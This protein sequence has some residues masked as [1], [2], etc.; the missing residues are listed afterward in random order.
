MVKIDALIFGYRSIRISPE[1]LSSVTSFL[2]RASIPSVINSDGSIIVRERD[3]IKTKDILQGRIEFTYSEPRGLYGSWKRLANKWAIVISLTLAVLLV[4][5]LSQLIWDIRVEGNTRI[6]DAQ[7]ISSLKECGFEIG[8]LWLMTDKGRI[9]TDFLKENDNVSWININRRGTVAYIKL[10]EREETEEKENIAVPKFSNILAD[11][12]CVIEEITVRRG[13]PM[14]KVGDVVKKGDILVAGV[15]SAESGGGFCEAD[16]TVMGRISDRVSVKI[17]R[18]EEKNSY[19]E[20]KLALIS[21]KIFKI[22][23]NIFKLYGNL[24]KECDIIENEIT[25]SLFGSYKL[26]L[27]VRISHLVEVSTERIEYTDEELVRIATDR[28][29]A[30]TASRLAAS[31]LL[32]IRTEG[33]FTDDG[34]LMSSDIVFLSDVGV[35]GEFEIE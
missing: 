10:I 6:T 23:L 15:L 22:S 7:V 4:I 21:I 32:R 19:K 24:T 11:S 34:Y 16:A 9:E 8:D 28:L 26:P 2:L 5:L 12:D 17:D 31:D 18:I 3:F 20:G 30:V 1:D 14:V 25:Y 35:S 13:T 33:E 27:S 29:N